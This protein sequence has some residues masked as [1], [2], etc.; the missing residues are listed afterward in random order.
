IFHLLNQSLGIAV[1]PPGTAEGRARFCLP[2]R[3]ALSL[4]ALRLLHGKA[5]YNKET[6]SA[7]S[8]RASRPRGTLF[9]EA[10]PFPAL[11]TSQDK[12]IQKPMLNSLDLEGRPQD[13]R[14]V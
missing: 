11:P 8:D 9:R 14:V 5:A 1:P 4:S 12:L 7:A 2:A 6:L 13:T 10:S 3:I